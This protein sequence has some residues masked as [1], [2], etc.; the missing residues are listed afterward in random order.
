M[1]SLILS[2]VATGLILVIA[3]ASIFYG[4]SAWQNGQS[5]AKAAR[6]NIETEQLRAATQYFKAEN[7]RLPVD[8]AELVNTKYL[9]NSPT[10]WGGA[11]NFFTNSV[12]IDEDTCL[13]FNQGRGIPFVPTCD[14]PVYRNLVVCCHMTTVTP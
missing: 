2:I 6:L 9:K 7:Q 12:S 14:D 3:L 4:G 10:E 11:T 1:F 8:L 13:I 5:K